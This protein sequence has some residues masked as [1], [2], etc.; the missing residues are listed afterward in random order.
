MIVAVIAMR[1]VQ[2]AVDQVIHVVAMRHGFV[3]AVWTVLV[4][5]TR[6]GRAT[7]G[8][9]CADRDHM[10]IDV[11][12]MHI[13]QMAVVKIIQMSIVAN[14]GVSA[15]WAML[16]GM[17]GM[18]LFGAGGHDARTF[19]FTFNQ[20][21]FGWLFR[22]VLNRAL[23]QSQDVGVGKRIVDVPCLSSPFDKP[24]LV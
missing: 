8:I 1:K 22:S 2:V 12:P 5:A 14:R 15:I 24:H 17:V 18:V 20:G 7:H 11:I 16:V 19:I 13:M 4:R 6:L 9:F 21:L 3:P 10:L 23:H